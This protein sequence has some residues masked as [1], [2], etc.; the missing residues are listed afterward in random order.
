[1]SFTGPA[2]VSSLRG[3][4][5]DIPG[6]THTFAGGIIANG[7]VHATDGYFTNVQSATTTS[8]TATIADVVADSVAVTNDITATNAIIQ[9]NLKTATL[10]TTGLVIQNR[11]VTQ[12][13][14][15][16]AGIIVM[17]WST[18]GTV[19][20]GWF[21]CNGTNGTPDLRNRFIV[22]AGA[23]FAQG[24]TGGSTTTSAAGAHDHGAAT[25]GHA[26][27]NDQIPP[28]IHGLTYSTAGRATNGT[29]PAVTFIATSAGVIAAETQ[30]TGGG[31]PHTHSITPVPTHTHTVTPAYYALIYIMKA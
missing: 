25:G 15:I 8:Q 20:T 10:D 11:F 27:T 1:M 19:P 14:I 9:G 5:V 24:T 6:Q 13:N 21:I 23:T 12:L 26:L 30:T 3:I 16:T 17:W 4:K 29:L 31:L 28:H 18:S 2:S 22:C 7:D